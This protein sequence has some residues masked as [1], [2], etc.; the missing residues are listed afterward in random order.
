MRSSGGSTK[1]QNAS[2]GLDTRCCLTYTERMPRVSNRG[3]IGV[4]TGLATAV[5]AAS[6][7]ATRPVPAAMTWTMHTHRG[8]IT[9][10][11]E[12]GCLDVTASGNLELHAG[13][14]ARAARSLRLLRARAARGAFGF[15][16][17]YG[18][19]TRRQ[20]EAL[21][22]TVRRVLA[23]LHLSTTGSP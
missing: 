6:A 4:A 5:L 20:T 17:G 23:S 11:L 2:T 3:A 16:D 22:A 7:G 13:T 9:L 19:C 18:P 10:A 14:Q 21:F 8:G 1:P 12:V 15:R